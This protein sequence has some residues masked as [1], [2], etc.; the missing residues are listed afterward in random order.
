[1][2]RLVTITGKKGNTRDLSSSGSISA[3]SLR[4]N[5]DPISTWDSRI[6]KGSFAFVAPVDSFAKPV[7]A[8]PLPAPWV[9]LFG[10][11]GWEEA[12][13]DSV[14]FG[15]VALDIVREEGVGK[16]KDLE[17]LEYRSRFEFE[18]F[19]YTCSL[20]QDSKGILPPYM[21]VY[22]TPRIHQLSRSRRRICCLYRPRP[23]EAHRAIRRKCPRLICVIAF[24]ASTQ[25]TEGIYET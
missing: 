19:E 12:G 18:C 24:I 15:F 20:P 11:G 9:G 16:C 23:C 5:R 4:S 13:Q 21:L 6:T 14:L 8:R 17:R 7:R 1:M 22:F 25:S 10:G 2:V 3:S